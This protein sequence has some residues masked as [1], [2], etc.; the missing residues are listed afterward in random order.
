MVLKSYGALNSFL[1]N[2]LGVIIIYKS[3]NHSVLKS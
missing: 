3:I 2:G 1:N